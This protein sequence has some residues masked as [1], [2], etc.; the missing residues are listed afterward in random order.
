MRRGR[1]TGGATVSTLNELI[2]YCNEEH[3]L[4]ALLLTGEWGCGKTFL[5]EK[6]LAEALEATHFI[7][8]VSLLGVDSVNSLD[9]AIRKQWLS[10]CTPFLGKLKQKKDN[11]RKNGSFL[12]VISTVLSSLNPVSGGIASAIVAVDPLEYIPLEPTV[13][14]FH[15]SGVKKKVVL[16]FDDLSRSRLD[17]N[18]IMGRIN[19]YCENMGFTTIV[20]AER[21]FIHS[22]LE[23]DISAYKM[24]KEKM[25]ARIVRYTPDYREIIHSIVTETPWQSEEYAA[26]LAEKEEI[27]CDAFITETPE[28]EGKAEKFHNFRSLN[29]AL[30]EFYRYYEKLKKR[31]VEDLDPYLYSFIAYI[32][33]SK[34]GICKDGQ[35]SFEYGDEDIKQLYPGYVPGS[36]P[37]SVRQ[38]IDHGIV[39]E[40]AGADEESEKAREEEPV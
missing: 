7:V 32:M 25:I 31:Q 37:E 30:Q 38:W 19:E 36:L 23:A 11:I 1:E 35:L 34:N 27:I 20:V 14:D 29:C 33:V 15:D 12:E 5:I 22:V 21:E 3:H 28:Q 2:R 26:F 10:V 24:I 8:R 39:E 4:G 18:S 17:L 40:D 13:E 9:D 16:V 6:R